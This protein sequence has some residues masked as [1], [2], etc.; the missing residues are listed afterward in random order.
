MI[1]EQKKKGVNCALYSLQ[2]QVSLM[3][4]ATL[5]TA[6]LHASRSPLE[7]NIFPALQTRASAAQHSMRVQ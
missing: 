6:V 5:Y 4:T 2:R 1:P 3:P 7:A